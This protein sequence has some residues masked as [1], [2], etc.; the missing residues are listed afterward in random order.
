MR[1]LFKKSIFFFLLIFTLHANASQPSDPVEKFLKKQEIIRILGID[2]MGMGD[3][4]ASA[5]VMRQLRNFGYEGAFE[6]VYTGDGKNVSLLFGLPSPL[7]DEYLDTKTKTRFVRIKNYFYKLNAGQTKHIPFATTGTFM[8]NGCAAILR[9]DPDDELAKAKKETM[10]CNNLANFSNADSFISLDNFPVPHKTIYNGSAFYRF[11]Q[12]NSIPFDDRKTYFATPVSTFREALDFLQNDPQGK[13]LIAKKPAL[14]NFVMGIDTQQFD[15]MSL[16]GWGVRGQD[17]IDTGYAGT[18]LQMISAA[19]YVQL[20]SGR[21]KP[22][23]IAV[24]YNYEKQLAE[25]QQ[26]IQYDHWDTKF[27]I[28]GAEQARA[29]I[30]KLKL[31][32]VMLFANLADASTAE[33]LK[34]L[35]PGQ[36]L[37]LG[38]G[39]LPKTVFDGLYTHVNTNIWPQLREGSSSFSS[40]LLSGRPHFRCGGV[41]IDHEFIWEIPF[42]N[43]KDPVLKKQLETLYAPNS[44]FCNGMT[45][46]NNSAE[47]YKLLGDL[48]QQALNPGSSYSQTFIE[49]KHDAENIDNNR[50][51][52]SIKQM[53]TPQNH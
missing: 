32:D 29:E 31:A 13:E 2:F 25:L 26:L 28:P 17:E 14:K 5:N 36:I 24:F 16:Y 18:M 44:I 30:K 41:Y 11:N 34:N 19:R 39:S 50:V 22:L 40:L 45:A 1:V 21:N 52:Q 38:V 46:W 8:Y 6:F 47:G 35:K 7:P 9:D 49:L 48:M 33:T 37:L 10:L 12:A 42:D 53:I 23:V 27:Q 20:N 4:A 43:I 15:V 51:Y 3:L